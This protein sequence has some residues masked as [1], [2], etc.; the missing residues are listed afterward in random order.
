MVETVGL[1][2]E[3]ESG[4]DAGRRRIPSPDPCAHSWVASP[5][6]L[7]NRHCSPLPKGSPPLEGDALD[8][9]RS[10]V[11]DRWKV[12]DG[13]H[14]EARFEFDDFLG[15]L[16]FTNQVGGVAEAEGHHPENDFLLA[17]RLDALT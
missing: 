4:R 5:M 11:S 8:P 10:A 6:D 16:A 14:L 9:Y 12:V 7:R 17:A 2:A 1:D 13:H 15:A 3:E